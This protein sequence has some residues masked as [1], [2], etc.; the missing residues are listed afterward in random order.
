ME[1]GLETLNERF[2]KK[3]AGS[4]VPDVLSCLVFLVS[5]YF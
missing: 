5:V 1:E 3:T 2:K 4:R